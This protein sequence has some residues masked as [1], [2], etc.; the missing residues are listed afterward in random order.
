MQTGGFTLGAQGQTRVDLKRE[1][2][3]GERFFQLFIIVSLACSLFATFQPSNFPSRPCASS[4]RASK[5]FF[6][7]DVDG[8]V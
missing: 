2:P 8:D 4:S 3:T 5:V 7:S 1:Q 6:S